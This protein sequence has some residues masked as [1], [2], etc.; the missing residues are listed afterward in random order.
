MSQI[1]LT[2]RNDDRTTSEQIFDLGNNLY[3][4]DAIDEAVERFKNDALPTVEREL[5]QQ[6]QAHTGARKSLSECER[7]R[8]R[9][10]LRTPRRL[11]LPAVA[12][13]RRG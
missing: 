3:S 2:L 9:H 8:Y 13:L 12:F 1:L 7:Q 10:R 5:L 4:L 11:R 6:A